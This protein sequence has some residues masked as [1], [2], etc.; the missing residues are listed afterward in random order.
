MVIAVILCGGNGTRLWPLSRE[1]R[2][3]QILPLSEGGSFLQ[4][5]VAHLKGLEEQPSLLP[6]CNEQHRFV[7]AE[8]LQTLGAVSETILLEPEGRNTAPAVTTAALFAREVL[9]KDPVLLVV[10]ADQMITRPKGFHQAIARGLPL[11]EAGR[12]VT[13]GVR[14]THAETS[15]GY[16]RQGEPL[17][18]APECFSVSRFVEKPPREKALDYVLAGSY[19]WNSGIFLFKASSWLESVHIHAPE[20]LEHCR[21]AIE[22]RSHDADFLR[23]DAAAF[24]ACPAASIDYAVMEKASNLVL[25]PMKAGWRDMGSFAALY[26]VGKR[27]PHGN[28]VVG[29]VIL[30]DVNH[31]YIHAQSRLIAAVG[32]ENAVVVE[33]KDVVLVAAQDRVDDVGLLVEALGRAG[34]PEVRAHRR[35]YRPWGSYETLDLGD[36]FHVKR[37]TVKPGGTLSLQKHLKR[38]EHWVV[39]KG[40]AHIIRGE[41]ALVLTED[42]STYI[43]LG[44]KHRLEN[45]GETPLEL[46][47]V[48]T[49]GYLGEDDIIRYDDRYGRASAT[50]PE[51]VD[52]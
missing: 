31:S 49:G 34:R 16:I 1:S 47:E 50:Q 46:I 26:A 29:D 22:G 17:E 33:T 52:G 20:V 9:H 27:D 38:A 19:F 4:D 51:P 28:R 15:Y 10:P 48:Q 32:L 30:Q 37:I 6:V 42:Q 35:V 2:P 44:V 43:P 21:L 5:M 39:V 13:F 45:R 12:L 11:A 7:V 24:Q 23:L 41:E 14:A 36:R 25:V 3:K 18:G 8:Q 40:T